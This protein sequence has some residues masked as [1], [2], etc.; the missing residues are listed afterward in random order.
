MKDYCLNQFQ[1]VITL[2]RVNSFVLRYPD[3]IIQIKSVCQEEQR[4]QVPR[5][6]FEQRMDYLNKSKSVEAYRIEVVLNLDKVDPSTGKIEKPA[7]LLYWRQS[8]VRKYIMKYLE[9]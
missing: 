7:K 6:L 2:S 8:A 9:R 5:V 4:L 3:E 1:A